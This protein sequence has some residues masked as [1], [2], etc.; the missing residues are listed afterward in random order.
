MEELLPTKN[1]HCKPIIGL[2][3]FCKL[4]AGFIL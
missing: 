2:I 1:Y 4:I 3:L